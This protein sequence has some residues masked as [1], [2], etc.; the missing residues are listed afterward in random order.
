M[1]VRAPPLESVAT[2]AAAGADG[3]SETQQAY[4]RGGDVLELDDEE[5][6]CEADVAI[7][8]VVLQPARLAVM[9]TLVDGLDQLVRADPAAST[10]TDEQGID[11][12]S[13]V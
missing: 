2:A 6:L 8:Q 5:P 7:L 1:C 12:L 13:Q 3:V 10:R 11:L 4:A 9:Q